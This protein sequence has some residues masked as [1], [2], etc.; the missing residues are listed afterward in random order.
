VKLCFPVLACKGAAVTAQHIVVLKPFSAALPGPRVGKSLAEERAWLIADAR[1]ESTHLGVFYER[2]AR[3]YPLSS[4]LV[5]KLLIATA[6]YFH[7]RYL[8]ACFP[9]GTHL[10]KESGTIVIQPPRY[11]CK[12][13][14]RH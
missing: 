4:S 6:E 8:A 13:K 3:F 5:R 14:S 2:C 1:Q 12:T 10:L 9:I 11:V 7:K